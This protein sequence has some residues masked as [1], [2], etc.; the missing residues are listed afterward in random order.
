M[1]YDE[2]NAFCGT[3]AATSHVVQWGGADVWKVAGKVFAI[4]GW[5]D[6]DGARFTFKASDI[7][8]EMLQEQPGLR[9]VPYLAPRGM[10]WIQHYEAPG[11]VGRRADGLFAGIAPHRVPRSF[12]KK[13]AR[14][15]LE[16]DRQRRDAETSNALMK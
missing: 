16:P 7:A 1:T 15:W 13:T 12:E 4:G 2:F 3:L 9:P 6:G 11:V 14:T 5:D 8:Y 10:K